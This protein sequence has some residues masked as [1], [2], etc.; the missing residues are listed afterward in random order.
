MI[1]AVFFDAAGTLLEPAEPVGETYARLA[2]RAG[3]RVDAPSLERAFH[4]AFAAAPPLALPPGA[5]DRAARER[6]WWRR[7]A[8]GAF[9][10][11]MPGAAPLPLEEVFASLFEHFARPDA[12]RLFADVRPTLER[13]GERGLA[14]AV[15]SNFDSRLHGV[16]A[17]LGLAA[18]FD[19]VILSSEC[20]F[21][22]PDAGIFAAALRA[23]RAAPEV[24]LHVGDSVARDVDGARRAGIAALRLERAG[25]PNADTICLLSELVERL[26]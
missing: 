15:V 25:T 1:R 21:A 13:L 10:D 12:W 5:D 2:A 4:R 18:A 20:G 19:A 14:L 3:V 22:K 26:R 9:A 24:A 17:G 11:A 23:V 8:F 6:E 16:L 7:I